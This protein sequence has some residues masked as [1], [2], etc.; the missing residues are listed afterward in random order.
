MKRKNKKSWEETSLKEVLDDMEDEW[1]KEIG[2]EPVIKHWD[3]IIGET[4]KDNCFLESIDQREMIVKVS[5]P[6]YAT[7]FHQNK[8][9]IM[10]RLGQKFPRYAN[11]RV[12]IIN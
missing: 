2:E 10:A 6:A 5:H 11:A 7:Y 3:F 9:Q 8:K 1:I 12:R 4:L